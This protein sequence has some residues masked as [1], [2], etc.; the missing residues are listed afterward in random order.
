M[1]KKYMK[2]EMEA[3]DIKPQGILCGSINQENDVLNII[4]M[5]DDEFGSD[6]TIN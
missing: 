6:E 5:T 1:K 2:P 3:I 4:L